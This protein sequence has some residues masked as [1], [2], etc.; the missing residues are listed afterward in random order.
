MGKTFFDGRVGPPGQLFWGAIDM[1]SLVLSLSFTISLFFFTVFHSYLISTGTTTIEVH[2][3]SS[4][5]PNPYNLGRER[6]WRAVFGDWSWQ[7]FFPVP[8]KGL[9]S[10]GVYFPKSDHL[11][12]VNLI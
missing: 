6:N 7:W 9:E 3:F 8:A 10:D 1:L 4:S 11:R 12:L 5:N 2:M